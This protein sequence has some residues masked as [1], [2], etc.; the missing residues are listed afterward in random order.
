MQRQGDRFLPV[1]APSRSNLTEEPLL[2]PSGRPSTPPVGEAS[3]LSQILIRLAAPP[4]HPKVKASRL[5]MSHG[6]GHVRDAQ[7]Q[8]WL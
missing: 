5:A 6:M 8:C 7:Y 2:D 3:R 1:V 4:P